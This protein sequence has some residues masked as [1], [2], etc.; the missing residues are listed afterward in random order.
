MP[1]DRITQN[2]GVTQT[3]E[4]GVFGTYVAYLH[5]LET[6]RD[7]LIGLEWDANE[8]KR[9][10]LGEIIEYAKRCRPDR[11]IGVKDRDDD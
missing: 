11:P 7:W 1:N 5:D 2:R 9:V 4:G 6:F 10:T 8:R 3:T